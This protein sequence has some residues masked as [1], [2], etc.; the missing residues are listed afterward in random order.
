[1]PAPNPETVLKID[2]RYILPNRAVIMKVSPDA[3]AQ[4]NMVK[5][6]DC[7]GVHPGIASSDRS[8][9]C[10]LCGARMTLTT[11]SNH[12]KV[13]ANNKEKKKF[14]CPDASRYFDLYGQP[15]P[16][17]SKDWLVQ[18][19]I[20]EE[21]KQF[22]EA[23][24]EEADKKIDELAPAAKIAARLTARNKKRRKH[25]KLTPMLREEK[26]LKYK[27]SKRC[28]K[29]RCRRSITSLRTTESI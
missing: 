23:A 18:E 13:R 5:S 8:F 17:R 26:K 29:K 3:L 6:V 25:R 24:M 27:N 19:K 22:V 11:L 20:P 4:Q 10:L 7:I 9:F 16:L 14:T 12:Y 1:M 21:Y 2:P 15:G 28:M